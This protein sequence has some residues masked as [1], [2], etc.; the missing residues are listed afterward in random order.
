MVTDSQMHTHIQ[1]N[2][3]TGPITIH[4]AA[5]LT[6]QSKKT[7]DHNDLKLGTVV[8]LDIV[9]KPG[10]LGFK[11]THRHRFDFWHSRMKSITTF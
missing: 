11:R 7:S 2:P 5:K 6:V 9:S 1:T 10:D 3:Q 4:C 8:I